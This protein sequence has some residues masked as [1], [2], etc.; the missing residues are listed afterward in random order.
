M[1]LYRNRNRILYLNYYDI[2]TAF[3]ITFFR[4]FTPQFMC[5]R[6]ALQIAFF[7]SIILTFVM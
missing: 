7:Y 3:E 1:G 5:L 6:I 4:N 2:N